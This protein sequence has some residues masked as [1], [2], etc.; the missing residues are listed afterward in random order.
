MACCASSSRRASNFCV[1][2]GASAF[3]AASPELLVRREGQ[4]VSTIALA[5][6]TRRSADPSVDDHLGEQMLRDPSLR[7]EHEIV[8]QR[9][10]RTLEPH[11]VW[12]AAAP[13]PEI[14]R[15]A[16]IQHLATPIRAQLARP[17]DTLEL[18][19][20]M[21]PTP[22]VGGEPLA[23]AAPM[24]PALEGLDRGWYSGRWA[25]R[26]RTATGSSAWRCAARCSKAA[27]RAVTPVAASC[28]T[29]S[30]TSSSPR[31]RSSFRRC[32]PA[33][34]LER[35]GDSAPQR[36]VQRDVLGPVGAHVISVARGGAN[37]SC[38]AAASSSRAVTAT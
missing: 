29:R 32:C 36:A 17:M 25:G 31:P 16:N 24:I 26:T 11:A 7:E 1:G 35:V 8:A 6:S 15:I 20:L 37:D 33:G 9:I 28:A 14:V 30:R 23:D 13:D 18:A 21:H 19:G 27:W 38:T 10:E 22:A 12:V 3:I 34:R 2:R 4:R 5:A